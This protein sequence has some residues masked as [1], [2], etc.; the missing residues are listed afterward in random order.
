MK[1]K[2]SIILIALLFPAFAGAVQISV[3]SAPAANYGLLS[4]SSGNYTP[5]PLST[6]KSSPG[7]S[8]FDIQANNGDGTFYGD[9]N[10]QYNG[11]I[12][13]GG[14]GA[15]PANSL[16]IFSGGLAIGPD[17]AGNIAAPSNGA[18]FEG[19]VGVGTSHPGG[20][21]E[22]GDSD[23][24]AVFQADVVNG[25]VQSGDLSHSGDTGVFSVSGTDLDYSGFVSH[26]LY[27]NTNGSVGINNA[28]PQYT[29]DVS[30]EARSAT[31]STT[32]Q[33]VSSLG[34]AAGTFVAA[35]PS[36]H[37]I[38]TSTPAFSGVTSV[39]LSSPNSTITVGSTP[40]TSSGTI[41]TDL[42]LAHSNTWSSLQTFGNASTSV[43]S[44]TSLC[45]TTCITAFPTGSGTVNTGLAGQNAYYAANGTVV[46]GTSTLFFATNSDIGIG[47]TT[48]AAPLDVARNMAANTSGAGFIL[49]NDT[50][51]TLN[52][53]SFSPALYLTGQ[54]LDGTLKTQIWKLEERPQNG[55]PSGAGLFGSFSLDG[56]VT[57]TD[58]FKFI[59][60]PNSSQTNFSVINGGVDFSAISLVVSNLTSNNN[61]AANQVNSRFG[62]SSQT[63]TGAATLCVYTTASA[64]RTGL[65]L[66]DAS[67][68]ATANFFEVRDT[69]NNV[70]DSFNQAGDLSIG[71]STTPAKLTI[72]APFGSIA[73]LFTIASTTSAGFATSSILAVFPNGNIGIGTSTPNANLWINGSQGSSVT[74]TA[75]SYTVATSSDNYIRV[76]STTLARTITLPLCNGLTIGNEYTVKDA[77]G[78]DSINHITI[79][80]N[81]SDL[82]DGA[83]TAVFLTNYQSATFKCAVAATWDV[84]N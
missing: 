68:A 26:I 63:C 12:G 50:V 83:S 52:N 27:A 17:Y 71:T 44:A 14:G 49:E 73:P 64:G 81:G 82:I 5:T 41:T 55:S 4:V 47:T 60:G 61:V 16:D 38:A 45:L 15:S 22:V 72:Q 65:V 2:I 54:T 59:G 23:S 13:I 25:V 1:R 37:L 21:F 19:T 3:P 39:G 53:F 36:G 6:F 70:L 20:T 40:V 18:I 11:G 66:M 69:S 30:G 31:A 42:N 10:F 48:P 84:I 51:P 79:A 77:S 35:D 74:S 28:S 78:L 29:L 33:Y 7:G 24:N 57:W 62:N 76:T 34:K 75:T 67:G 80:A 58:N 56:G 43:L 32:N 46:S 8:T 9:N